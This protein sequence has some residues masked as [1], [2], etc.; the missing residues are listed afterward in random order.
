MGNVLTV[1]LEPNFRTLYQF[2]RNQSSS[3]ERMEQFK[4]LGTT[5]TDQNYIRE[6]IDLL[7]PELFF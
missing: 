1:R 7:A 2:G 5:L 6:E 3:F 4:Y